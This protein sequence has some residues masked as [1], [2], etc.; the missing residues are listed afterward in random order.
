MALPRDG[1]Q[2]VKPVRAALYVRVSTAKRSDKSADRAYEQNPD[3]QESAL[4]DYARAR[5]WEVVKTYSDRASGAQESRPGLDA[6]MQDA[7][8]RRFDLVLVW[9]FDRFA[10]SVKHLILALEEFQSLNLQFVSMQEALDTSTPMG[11]VI[12]AVFAALAQY[13]RASIRERVLAGMAHAARHGT[14]SGKPVGRPRRVV[15]QE[16][17]RSLRVEGYSWPE[18]AGKLGV[19]LSTVQRV[20]RQAREMRDLRRLTEAVQ[21]V[22]SAGAAAAAETEGVDGPPEA[23]S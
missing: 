12:F 9:R 21:N 15:D 18:I 3:V 13:E 16:V 2:S 17:I 8:R 19:G 14:K 1:H 20:S 5:G 10:R 11:Y 7:R 6:M 22:R 4:W 23:G